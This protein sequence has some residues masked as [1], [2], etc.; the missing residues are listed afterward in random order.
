MVKFLRTAVLVGCQSIQ[1][2]KLTH[3]IHQFK[4]DPASQLVFIA[5]TVRSLLAIKIK[6]NV[7][8]SFTS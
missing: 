3:P 6:K 4:Y 1:Q 2:S 8:T 7:L 5:T